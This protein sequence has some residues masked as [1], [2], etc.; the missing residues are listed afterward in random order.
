MK[1]LPNILTILRLFLAPLFPV[2]YFSNHLQNGS[3]FA[4]GI[5]I[6]AGI[7]DVLDGYLARKYKLVTKIGT[8]LDPLADKLMLISALLTLTIDHLLPIFIVSFVIIKEFLMIISGIFL[9]FRKDQFVIPSNK[10]GKAATIFFFLGVLETL[11][12][13]I[14][15]LNIGLFSL[16]I[17]IRLT[18]LYTYIRHYKEVHSL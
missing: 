5:Y 17:L 9:Y 12:F 16:A 14:E 1:N 8:V 15:L 4:M 10:Y 11:I 6:A 3:Y 2:V 18:A 13:N 7:T